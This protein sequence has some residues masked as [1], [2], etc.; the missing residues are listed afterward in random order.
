MAC[1]VRIA[2][3]ALLVGAL[4]SVVL[5]QVPAS[6][7]VAFHGLRFPASVAG[8]ERFSVHDYEKRS[9]GLGYS[10]GYRQPGSVTTVYIYDLKKRDIPDDPSAPAI[11]AQLEAAKVDMLQ[12][13]R[14]GAYLKIEPNAQ[15]SIADARTRTRLLCV[16]GRLVRTDPPDERLSDVC[17]GGWKQKFIK[18]RTT[19]DQQSQA[20]ALGFLQAWM[21]LLRPS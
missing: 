19:A 10:V 17:V 14:Q 18:F 1:I 2:L 11:K 21:D 9:P 7:I 6:E 16:A 15:F 8:A 12:A 4:H 20:N 5:A 3:S 13:P